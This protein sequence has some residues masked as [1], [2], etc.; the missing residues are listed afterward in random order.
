MSASFYLLFWLVIPAIVAVIAY[1]KG[2]FWASWLVYGLLLWPVALIH[3]LCARNA[4]RKCP[5]CAERI[6]EEASVCKHC[7]RNVPSPGHAEKAASAKSRKKRNVGVADN[8]QPQPDAEVYEMED[9][10]AVIY[11]PNDPAQKYHIVSKE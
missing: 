2:K 8:S 7:G 11:T 5:H 6:L 9:G 10:T 3:I 4:A 1:T